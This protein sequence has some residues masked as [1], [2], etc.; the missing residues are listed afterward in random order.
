M[1][2]LGKELPWENIGS[3]RKCSND[4][5]FALSPC[6][7]QD[8]QAI[9]PYGQKRAEDGYGSAGMS[10]YHD[11]IQGA[12]TWSITGRKSDVSSM[13]DTHSPGVG[14][15]GPLLPQWRSMLP[16]LSSTTARSGKA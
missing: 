1:A 2:S 14:A 11:R 10:N 13:N 6:R 7:R 4:V 16:P 12:Y 3:Q 15:H 5:P 9:A 8:K